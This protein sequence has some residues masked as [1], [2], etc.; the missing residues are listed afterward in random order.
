[1]NKIR[2]LLMNGI[3]L[4]GLALGLALPAAAVPQ[5]ARRYNVSCTTCHAWPS[6]QLTATGLDFLRR[7]HRLK[8]DGFDKD[9]THLLSAHVEWEYD[10]AQ[11][12]TNQFNK[13]E[14]HLHAGGAFSENFSGYLDANVNNDIEA[15]YAQFTKEHGD[16]AYFTV[17][18]GK[19]NP[20]LLRNYS[21]G[22]A[23]SAS[24]PLAFSGTTLGGN[25]FT[26]NQAR[27]GV[28]LGGRVKN[29][30][31]QG[32]VVN[33]E[34]VPGQATV[35]HHKDYYGTAEATAPDGVSGIGLYYYHGA[36]DLG[37]PAAGPLLGDR[38]YRSAVFANFNRDSFRVAAAYLYGKD[39]VQTLPDRKLHG[40]YA[41]VE[42]RPG[43]WWV[44]FARYDDATTEL[45]TGKDHV[46]QGTLG[47]ALQLYQNEWTAGR[48]VI[49][50][51]RSSDPSTHTNTN[52]G[53]LNLVWAF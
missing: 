2:G 42:I 1:M 24:Q 9:L 37:D 14:L 51:A 25:P 34:D 20:T 13:P 15:G 7:G 41:L 10:F 52:S 31:V 19:F 12:A 35:N 45:E 3:L 17:R 4:G 16:D 29:L 40:Y 47:V 5:W 46:R 43:G 33:G 48:L 27:L 11:G 32:G 36:Y 44:P 50:L 18:G 53:L 28:D 26:T 30:F 22:L 6:E 23:A 8:G 38:Y 21:G 39:Q 49:E